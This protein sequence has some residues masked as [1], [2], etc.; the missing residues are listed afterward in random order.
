METSYPSIT[1]ARLATVKNTA[2]LYQHATTE[3]GLRW[4][5]FN[6]ER[7]GFSQCLR[8]I[9]RKILIDLDQFENW[10]EQ[11]GEGGASCK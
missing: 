2:A 4:L 8:R 6:E 1:Q 7:N 3:A 11:Q 9:G 10:I 5:I